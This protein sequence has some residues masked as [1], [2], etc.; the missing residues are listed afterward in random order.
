MCN[1]SVPTNY[2]SKQKLNLKFFTKPL[3]IHFIYCKKLERIFKITITYLVKYSTFNVT[4]IISVLES[5][6]ALFMSSL[7]KIGNNLFIRYII[8]VK[9]TFCN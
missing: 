6:K 4:K 2:K 3:S 1:K 7:F 5:I 9:C 8:S